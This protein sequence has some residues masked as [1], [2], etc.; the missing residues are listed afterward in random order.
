MGYRPPLLSSLRNW[1]YRGVGLAGVNAIL[2]ASHWRA[3]KLLIL[4]YHGISLDDEHQWSG[5]YLAPQ[6]FRER[7]RCITSAGC[8]VLPLAAALQKL[9]EGDLPPR[10]VT[11]TFDD[12]FY[13]F[14]ARAWPLLRDFGFPATVYFPT[15]YSLY[16]VPV[17][18]PMCSYLFWKAKGREFSWPEENFAPVLLDEDSGATLTARV[19][20]ICL[21]R[22]LSGT[23]KNDLLCRLAGRLGLDFEDLCARRILHLMN[24][25]EAAQ[26]SRQ[27][28]DFQ[29]H[30]HRHRVY[31]SR[32]NFW[33]ELGDNR[34]A[35][36][37]IT[38]Q[39]PNHFC[40]P[41]GFYLPEFPDWLSQFGIA[42]ATTCEIGLATRYSARLAL[43]RLLD[44][45]GIG[46]DEFSA[47]LS[48][49]ADC[50]PRKRYPPAEGQLIEEEPATLHP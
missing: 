30:C 43:P 22:R 40:Y 36:H 27:G 15:Y 33:Q 17:F 18:D 50:L 32:E 25:D 35:I 10:A 42:S 37:S 46:M 47:W 8:V 28:V 12:G 24:P 49:L 41:G 26:V 13:D 3:R 1:F 21:Q 31:R 38:G 2:L 45:P 48:G 6:L 11:I 34:E 19:K 16:N 44:T 29:L 5:L 14:Y 4:C 7:L 20:S 9:Y 23:E 39:S